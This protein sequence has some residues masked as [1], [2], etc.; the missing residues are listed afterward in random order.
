MKMLNRQNRIKIKRE[1]SA[2]RCEICHQEDLY[3]KLSNECFRCKDLIDKQ[4]SMTQIKITYPMSYS[5]SELI[6]SQPSFYERFLVLTVTHRLFIEK[7]VFF[8][9]L[10]VTVIM[11]GLL[12][13]NYSVVFPFIREIVAFALVI[14]FMS[15]IVLAAFILFLIENL[16]VTL[17][18]LSLII[19]LVVA[20]RKIGRIYLA[21]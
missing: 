3:D 2:I 19:F 18:V 11:C 4:E 13:N 10:L 5:D 15:P 17:T 9:K 8:S 16:L 20:I 6:I 12:I 1:S 7:I 21:I 14:V